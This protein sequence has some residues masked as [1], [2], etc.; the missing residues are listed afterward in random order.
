MK[1]QAQDTDPAP[2]IA[3]LPTPTQEDILRDQLAT[4]LQEKG[5]LAE[6]LTAESGRLQEVATAHQQ[7]VNDLTTA[8]ASIVSLTAT[9]EAE[10]TQHVR[11]MREAQLNM[12][13]VR[14]E[15][16][17]VSRLRDEAVVERDEAVAQW[18]EWSGNPFFGAV[19]ELCRQSRGVPVTEELESEFARLVDAINETGKG[20]TVTLTLGAKVM[21][22]QTALIIGAKVT[23]KLPKGDA[24]T[25]IVFLSGGKVTAEDPKLPKRMIDAKS[26]KPAPTPA[27][28]AT[29]AKLAKAKP[30]IVDVT[31]EPSLTPEEEEIYDH[32]AVLSTQE[33]MTAAKL[34]RRLKLSYTVAAK[35]MDALRARGVAK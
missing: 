32:A 6:Q 10:Q 16:E 7:A 20:G 19:I 14:A 33:P 1:T 35:I 8:K 5:A 27:E 21:E 12:Q 30:V 23:S 3:A 31:A 9:L 17:N 24:D 18:Q 29:V 4:L 2:G 22:G 26:R 28:Q 13:S 25:A 15:I 34:Q 11:E